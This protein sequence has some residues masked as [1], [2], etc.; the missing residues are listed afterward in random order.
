MGQRLIKIS[1]SLI[2]KKVNKNYS[3]IINLLLHN[4]NNLKTYRR[5]CIKRNTKQRNTKRRNTKQRNKKRRNTK[6][7]NKKRR[8]TKRRNTNN[9]NG[10]DKESINTSKSYIEV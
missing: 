1:N 2:I 4:M 6:Q 7:R 8:N 9:I 5:R 10:G 3:I